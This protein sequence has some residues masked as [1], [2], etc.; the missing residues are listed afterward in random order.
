LEGEKENMKRRVE[1]SGDIFRFSGMVY[2]RRG[3]AQR[4]V[5]S[6]VVD[7]LFLPSAAQLSVPNGRPGLLASL[8]VSSWSPGL[9][10]IL[11]VPAGAKND[12]QKAMKA[13]MSVRGL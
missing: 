1:V 6:P 11:S 9:S 8:S 10:A 7:V 12:L 13:C 4:A 3:C 5:M 2:S